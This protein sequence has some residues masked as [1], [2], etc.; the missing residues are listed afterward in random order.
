MG[1]SF[2]YRGY[3]IIRAR[4]PTAL[5]PARETWDIMYDENLLKTNIASAET[6][7]H[8]VDIMIQYY[9]LHDKRREK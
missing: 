7:K 1:T 8:F 2:N 9:Y 4:H 3:T 6:A 5:N